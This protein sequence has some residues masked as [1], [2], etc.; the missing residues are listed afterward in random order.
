MFPHYFFMVNTFS[1][2]RLFFLVLKI[3]HF[4]LFQ[5]LVAPVVPI[6]RTP[7]TLEMALA[8]GEPSGEGGKEGSVLHVP[9]TSL[10]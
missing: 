2:D 4:L 10:F 6:S 8:A 5:D 9:A 1:S 3:L 7:V